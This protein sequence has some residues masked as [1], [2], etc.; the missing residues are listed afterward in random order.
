MKGTPDVFHE[1]DKVIANYI[2]YPYCEIAIRAVNLLMRKGMG[3][4]VVS[5]T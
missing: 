1:L 3:N 2:G 4:T 5:A